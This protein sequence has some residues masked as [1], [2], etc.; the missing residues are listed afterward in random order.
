MP[1]RPIRRSTRPATPLA[2]AALLALPAAAVAENRID[3][4]RPDAPELAAYG[5]LDVGTRPLRLVNPDQVDVVSIDPEADPGTP[6][7]TYDRS[8][9]LQVWYPSFPG[10]VGDTSLRAFLRDG[11][12]EVEL[13]GRAVG[14]A[15]PTTAGGPYPLVIVSHGYPGNRFLLSHLAENLAS[16]GYVV[17]SI[18]HA[19][20]TY[21]DLGAFGSTLRNR[22]LD[23]RF[24]LGEMDRLSTDSGSF[25]EGLVDASNTAI[26][27]YSMGGYGA[28]IA[29]GGGLAESAYAFPFSPPPPVLDPHLAGSDALAAGFDERVRTAIAFAPWGRNTGFFDADSLE[30]VRIPMLFV[31]G[32]A[33]DVSGYE[34]GIRAIWEES[35][36]VDRS[37]LTFENANHNA[38]APYPAPEESYE[39]DPTLGFAPFEHYADA[40]WDTVR[41]NN[42][43]QHFA[44][45]WL[46]LYLKGDGS[47]APYLELVPDSDDGTYAVDEDGE[48][49]EAHDYWTGFA[50]RTAKGMRFESLAAGERAGAA[51]GPADDD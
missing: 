9:L 19:D 23:Q 33:D 42:V 38:G 16:K 22:T 40:V 27:G 25:L 48:F 44:T 11:T 30:G 34:N 51:D 29:A 14:Y 6:L 8:L 17:A 50:D 10:A 4:Q 5:A 31:A 32:S 7:P 43:S 35:V 46:D 12:T 2:I 28:V 39:F 21:R 26:V 45:A 24:V 20:S 41:M 37:L 49:T 36:N 18:D 1:S 3:V 15:A 47:R 13:E